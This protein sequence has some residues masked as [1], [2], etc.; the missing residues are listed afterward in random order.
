ML[1]LVPLA[2]VVKVEREAEAKVSESVT[3][4]SPAVVSSSKAAARIRAAAVEAFAENGYGGTTTRDIAARLGLSP[5]AMYPHYKSKEELLYAISYEGHQRCVELLTDAD[6]VDSPPAARLR[7]V[8]GAFTRW[9]AKHHA[10]GRVVQY[11]LTALSPEHYR[12]IIGLRRDVNRIVK[13]IVKAGA[14]DGSFVVPDVEGVTLAITSLCV[15]VCRWFP[16]GGFSEP[17]QVAELYSELALRLVAA[18][19]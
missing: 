10:R 3:A 7:A 17:D 16:G 19:A 4:E 13:R 2:G 14:A 6:P 11:E 9:H 15:D 8:V 1:I 12:T 5:A 18:T